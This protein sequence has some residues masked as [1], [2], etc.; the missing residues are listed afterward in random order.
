MIKTILWDFDGVILNSMKIKGDGFI[1]LF[2]E[3]SS[4]D[5][6]ELEN[7]HYENGGISRF[8][9]IK[10][11]FEN[12]L[13]KDISENEIIYLAKDF[14]KII[15]VNLSK[16]DNLITETVEFILK[17]YMNFNFH[18]VSGAEH[19]ELNDL[20]NKFEL[21]NYFKS[22]SGS[23]TKKDILIAQ[24]VAKYSYSENEMIL[25]GDSINDYDASIKNNI[26][27]FGY[28]NKKLKNISDIY[29]DDFTSFDTYLN[30][31]N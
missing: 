27:F 30:R 7:Y 12:I 1:E 14:S 6:K 31:I 26:R 23:P 28:N 16:K 2:K 24:V 25:I 17:N 5:V 10:F 19:N 4:K 3:Y 20:C 22:I 13:K 9:K 15:E 18:I 8:L 11:F 29:I 21:K